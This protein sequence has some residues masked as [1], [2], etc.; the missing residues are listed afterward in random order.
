VIETAGEFLRLISSDDAQ[1]RRRAVLDAAPDAVWRELMG[2]S[3]HRMDV[4]LNKN[5]PDFVLETLAAD[6]DER[7]RWHVALKRR[8]PL[9]VREALAA[10]VDPGVRQRVAL[11]PKTPVELLRVLEDDPCAFVKE[12]ARSRLRPNP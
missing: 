6:E 1:E 9:R 5:L 7:V 2:N 12:A 11:N 8:L 3:E 4:V 10:D